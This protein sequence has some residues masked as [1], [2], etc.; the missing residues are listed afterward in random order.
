MVVRMNRLQCPDN[1]LVSAI[2][3]LDRLV[4]IRVG[5]RGASLGVNRIATG[6]GERRQVIL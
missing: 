1:R 3:T 2:C 5:I 4:L 6:I